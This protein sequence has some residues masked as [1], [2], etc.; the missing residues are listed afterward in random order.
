M[1]LCILW[2]TLC[3]LILSGCVTEA[4]FTKALDEAAK[5]SAAAKLVTGAAERDALKARVLQL[6]GRRIDVTDAKAKADATLNLVCNP[7]FAIE[8]GGTALA[9]FGDAIDTVHKVGE[10][11][12]NTSYA[13]Y[14]T[15]FRKNAKNIADAKKNGVQAAMDA[16]DEAARKER[17][18]GVT[19]C[20]AL[21]QA[22]VIAV[23]G[24]TSTK[25]GATNAS[26]TAVLFAFNEV[27]KA[28]LAAGEAAQRETAVIETA[29]SL[30]PALERAYGNLVAPVS[31]DFQP[32]VVYDELPSIHPAP[33]GNGTVL[34]ATVT[35]HRW[36]IA[37]QIAQTIK[38]LEG[39]SLA[40]L[41]DPVNRQ[42]LDEL[43]TAIEQYRALATVNSQKTLKALANGIT[44]A[45]KVADGKVSWPQA[46][47]GLL[48]IV[49]TVSGLGDKFGSY[50]KSRE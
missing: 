50:K 14:V 13:S 18:R 7:S 31:T 8:A 25:I 48:Q 22:D 6:Y 26:G 47:D 15:Q 5:V 40:C 12:A 41:G 28:A 9:A 21:Y 10:K 44:D 42:N 24:P 43:T 35:L 45:K 2:S 37:Q 11:P 49:D 1:K 39:C 27:I 16:G 32:F 17:E 46:L 23:L 36:F 33:A 30:I 19:L 3:M 20:M 4:N 34:G 29:K 38:R